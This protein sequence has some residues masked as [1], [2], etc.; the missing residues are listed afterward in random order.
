MVKSPRK[1]RGLGASTG[2]QVTE[3]FYLLPKIF[4]QTS[5]WRPQ[6]KD[7]QTVIAIRCNLILIGPKSL[8]RV[9][10]Q[11]SQI[12]SHTFCLKKTGLHEDV[13]MD[14]IEN[15]GKNKPPPPY[16]YFLLVCHWLR[17][18]RACQKP[19]FALAEPVHPPVNFGLADFLPELLVRRIR[20][21]FAD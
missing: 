3:I 9:Y 8:S 11:N 1:K 12:F 15:I 20:R 19:K 2:H 7:A 16:T 21:R 18:C 4:R 6:A 5:P 13:N 10:L 14:N 17:Q